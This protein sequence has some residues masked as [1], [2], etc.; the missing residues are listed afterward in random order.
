MKM[1][2]T[3]IFALVFALITAVF[4]VINVGPV[5]V[6]YLFGS[7]D[8]PLILVIL[9]STLLGGLITGLFGIIRQYRLQ[10]RIKFL[11]AELASLEPHH[12]LT[13]A[14]HHKE[15][16]SAYISDIDSKKDI[17]SSSSTSTDHADPSKVSS[18]SSSSSGSDSSPSSS[19][20][21]R[22][23]SSSDSGSSSSD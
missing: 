21:S 7:A 5:Q 1:Q 12:D 14:K 2:W 6:N 9:G 23:S 4:A 16:S 8:I 3:L 11:E 20:D 13:E 10:R 22:P 18:N 15:I 17:P 19:S